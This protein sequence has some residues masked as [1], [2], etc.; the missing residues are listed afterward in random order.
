MAYIY[1]TDFGYFGIGK[2][3]KILRVIAGLTQQDLAK[4]M[5][6]PNYTIGRIENGEI[7]FSD[8]LLKQ[9]AKAIDMEDYRDLLKEHLEVRI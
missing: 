1:K 8:K 3:A 4:R 7:P 5:R 2:R 9:F 6:V